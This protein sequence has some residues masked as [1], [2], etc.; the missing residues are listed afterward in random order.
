M[1]AIA[2]GDLSPGKRLPSTRALAKR[3]RLN[4]NTVSAAYQQLESAGWVQ[5]VHGSGVFVR[6]KQRDAALDGDALDRLVVPFIRAARVS[7]ISANEIRNRIDRLLGTPP[8]RFVFVHPEQELRAIIAQELR[9]AVSWPVA[10]CDVE[11]ASIAQYVG[12]SAF[13]TVPSK[14]AQ[15]QGL[16]P[17]AAEVLTLQMRRVDQ[18]LAS[19]LPIPAEVLLVVAS[20]WPG[21]L[22]I[23]RTM[24]TA[25]G[26]DPDA[27][28]F[29]DTR[30]GG[31]RRNLDQASAI[32][33]DVVTSDSIPDG[34]PKIVFALVSDAGIAGLKSFERF[35]AK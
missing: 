8:K 18:A 33:C 6:E 2:S 15:V 22:R 24:L 29:G 10:A 19:Y 31:W 9:S 12:D 35:F 34:V 13:V 5:S 17:A 11:P 21:F 25:A 32:L 23:A 30:A 1:L 4:V 27:V 3:F 28:L 26:F 7:G 16:L 14:Q 20:G